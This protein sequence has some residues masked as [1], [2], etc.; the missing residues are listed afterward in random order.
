MFFLFFP[1][2]KNKKKC[3]SGGYCR[4]SQWVNT[5]LMQNKKDC[6]QQNKKN[7]HFLLKVDVH[8]DFTK[9]VSLQNVKRTT[10][11]G[12]IWF[13]LIKFRIVRY[14]HIETSNGL[15]ALKDIV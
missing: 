8:L 10:N 13:G 4:F 5:P 7:T 2:V 3:Q 15:Y 14:M 6:V 11:E 1:M 12:F 9:V